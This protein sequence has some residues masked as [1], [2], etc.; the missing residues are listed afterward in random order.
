MS[1][2]ESEQENE[3]FFRTAAN[4][5]SE[6]PY[7]ENKTAPISSKSSTPRLNKSVSNI[8]MSNGN[9]TNKTFSVSGG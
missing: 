1:D 3:V 8:E 7:Q 2:S 4:Q 5:H 9:T 6:E